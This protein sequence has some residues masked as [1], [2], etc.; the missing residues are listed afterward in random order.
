M[1]WPDNTSTSMRHDE[2]RELLGVYALDA[3]EPSESEAVEAH[4]SICPECRGEVDAH[5]A[6]ASYLVDV[7]DEAPAHLWDRLND[8]IHRAEVV[9]FRRPRSKLSPVFAVAAAILVLAGLVVQTI[10]LDQTK[11]ELAL[12][13][14]TT[15]DLELALAAGDLQ[16]AA[17]LASTNPAAT[18]AVIDGSL[19]AGTVI[20]LPNGVGFLIGEDLPSLDNQHTYQ[21]WAIQEGEV[22]SAGILGSNPGVTT[23]TIERELL[24]GL[25]ITAEKAGGV[26]QSQETVVSAWFPE[27]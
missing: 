2:I 21:L 9:E 27:T 17:T 23:F 26:A 25:V 8:G 6:A 10:R 14:Q 7:S 16:K 18:T 20:I 24:E 4:L 22:V 19:G 11:V 5:R 1:S 13:Q 15:S 12:A 3:I